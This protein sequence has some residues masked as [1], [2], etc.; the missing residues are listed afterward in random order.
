MSMRVP[1]DLLAALFPLLAGVTFSCRG[2][3]V[4]EPSAGTL[5]IVIATSG[6]EPD[7]DG[8]T[9]QLDAEPPRTVGTTA[10]VEWIELAPG[11]HTLSLDGLAANCGVIGENPR[12]VSIRA[13][14]TLEVAFQVSC[15]ATAKIVFLSHR[16]GAYGV[17]TA[18][19][20]GTGQTNLTPD[21]PVH[22]HA[23]PKWSPDGSKIAFLSSLQAPGS[24]SDLYTMNADGTGKRN[25][26]P[27]EGDV[28]TFSWSPDGGK[29]AS[30]GTVILI[31]NADGT[32]SRSLTDGFAPAWSPDGGRIAFRS[33]RG[34]SIINADGSGRKAL[35]D[36]GN[37]QVDLGARWSPDG[38]VIAFTRDATTSGDD[39]SS[40]LWLMNAD[41]SNPR[42]LTGI[43]PGQLGDVAWSHDGNKLVFS[44][45]GDIYLIDPDGA[46]LTNLT[47]S[48][49]LSE[50]NPDW[51]SDDSRILFSTWIPPEQPDVFVMAA[52]GSQVVNL[53]SN[54]AWDVLPRWQPGR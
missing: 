28:S 19:L 17:Y 33:G 48:P 3:R 31:A 52:D 4:V 41:G 25:L 6:A 35:T 10:S 32:D 24:P 15:T 23:Q 9:V 14:E 42:T 7:P 1:R 21:V 8:Y 51:S 29:L 45:G 16:G 12:T 40:S 13:G 39:P 22:H 46:G 50:S 37:D 30:S 34:I 5:E 36:P 54:P 47:N 43:L 49:A 27:G 11:S 53:T 18:N 26:T 38:R 44:L 2:E 20:D